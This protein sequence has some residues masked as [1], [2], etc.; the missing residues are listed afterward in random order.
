MC[1][2]HSTQHLENVTIH[3]AADY[4]QVLYNIYGSFVHLNTIRKHDQ[5]HKKRSTVNAN[6]ENILAFLARLI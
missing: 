3:D 4:Q 6:T 5:K 1:W 2:T